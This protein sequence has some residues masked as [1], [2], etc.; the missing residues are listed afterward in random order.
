MRKL[1]SYVFIIVYSLDL[2]SSLGKDAR[3][4]AQGWTHSSKR[5][6]FFF[7]EIE[8]IYFFLN[9][10]F[11]GGKGERAFHPSVRER[12]EDSSSSSSSTCC[13][14][15]SGEKVIVSLYIPF[16]L[17]FNP[18]HLLCLYGQ[19]YACTHTHDDKIQNKKKK[20][21]KKKKKN[22]LLGFHFHFPLGSSSLKTEKKK[23]HIFWSIRPSVRR[24]VVT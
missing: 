16:S 14:C 10:F 17:F 4:D 20:K 19:D 11:S 6:D 21:K 15:W 7:G 24:I 18:S 12:D 9:V 13:C 8:G 5:S 2:S 23:Q 3:R 1:T 22:L